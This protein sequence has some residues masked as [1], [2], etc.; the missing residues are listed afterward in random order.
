M[1]AP[2]AHEHEAHDH[3]TCVE[4]L[5][6]RAEAAFLDNGK[7]LTT[8]RMQVLAEIAASHDAVGAY[9]VLDRLAQ[10]S[11]G[12]LA[13]ISVYRAIDALLDAGLI[14]RLESKNAFYA[15]HAV[16]VARE[17]HIAL[18]CEACDR[19]VEVP[20][21]GLYALIEDASRSSGFILG[22]AVAEGMGH[23]AQCAARRAADAP[24]LHKVSV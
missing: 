9:A 15:C 24:P 12:R 16:H 7:K 17:R 5:L 19:V 13:P 11:G 3:T 6:T 4:A 22:A 23:C 14:H 21:Q 10:K 2:R 1:P 18:V 8:L 20:A